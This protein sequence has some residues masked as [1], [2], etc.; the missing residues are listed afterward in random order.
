MLVAILQKEKCETPEINGDLLLTILDPDVS[1]NEKEDIE[2]ICINGQGRKEIPL[3]I[4][5]YNSRKALFNTLSEYGNYEIHF[6]QSTIPRLSPRGARARAI[7][8]YL[9]ERQKPEYYD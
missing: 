8:D 2:F 4:E 7:E 3:P 5:A 9:F 6:V 1:L